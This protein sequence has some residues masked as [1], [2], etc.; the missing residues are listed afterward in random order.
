MKCE[1]VSELPRSNHSLQSWSHPLVLDIICLS[2]M[3]NVGTQ[4]SFVI[5]DKSECLF[6]LVDC[7]PST[8]S[9]WNVSWDMFA[10][11]FVACIFA[12]LLST[13]PR[14]AALNLCTIALGL[15]YRKLCWWDA[16][17]R[18]EKTIDCNRESVCGFQLLRMILN[19]N[20]P[21]ALDNFHHHA[22]S[23]RQGKGAY[24]KRKEV[25]GWFH[26]MKSYL[27]FVYNNC[28]LHRYCGVYKVLTYSG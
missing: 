12:G 2:I 11:L 20:C 24:S 19:W 21:L 28:V 5:Q 22:W 15:F 23:S 14:I 26:K 18:V 16:L 8:L 10:P 9:L 27:S 4:D 6:S 13:V 17:Q 1:R 25:V 7:Q 3:K